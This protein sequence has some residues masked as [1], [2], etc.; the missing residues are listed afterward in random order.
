MSLQ[1]STFS[2]MG[3]EG[4]SESETSNSTQAQFLQPSALMYP[5]IFTIGIVVNLIVLCTFYSA[6]KLTKII[7]LVCNMA[8][9]DFCM[10][11]TGSYLQ[12]YR[13]LSLG[14]DLLCQVMNAA[15]VSF[16]HVSAF[17]IVVIAF[18]R[19]IRLNYPHIIV[20]ENNYVPEILACVGIW[21]FAIVSAVPM[22]VHGGFDGENCH[23]TMSESFTKVYFTIIF[24]TSYIIPGIIVG[25]L[26][27]SIIV[28]TCSSLDTQVIQPTNQHRITQMLAAI[29][30]LFWSFHMPFWYCLFNALYAN[31]QS[32][33]FTYAI[34]LTYLN[35]ATD[36]F[37][38]FMLRTYHCR[39]FIKCFYIRIQFI[40]PC[41]QLSANMENTGDQVGADNTQKT[42]Y[43]T[44]KYSHKTTP[45]FFVEANAKQSTDQNLLLQQQRTPQLSNRGCELQGI[46]IQQL[47]AEN[48]VQGQNANNDARGSSS[49]IIM[50]NTVVK[51]RLNETGV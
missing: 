23:N 3:E 16:L 12:Y 45:R 38:Y 27:T 7:V 40:C 25:Y 34:V 8:F 18:E 1:T 35:A 49:Y 43:Q 50:N 33:H 14:D 42:P 39:D 15:D 11:C 10:L 26:Y 2:E 30:V 21:T 19:F 6:G 5:P 51:H 4:S 32:Q 46:H 37:L 13:I 31:Y 44:P 47:P 28:K 17:T 36:P 48:G 29:I 22:I 24:M 20:H 9:A 41:R